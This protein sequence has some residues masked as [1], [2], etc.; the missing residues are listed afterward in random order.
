[1]HTNTPV[2]KVFVKNQFLYNMDEEIEGFTEGYIFGV[3]SMRARALLFHVMLKSGAHW[4]GLPIHSMWWYKPDADEKIEY[5]DLENLQLWDCFTEKTQVIQWDY[6]LGHQCDCFLRNK[7]VVGGEYWCSVEWLKDGNP[8]TSFVSTSDQDK[9]AHLIKLDNGQIAALPTNRIAFK[10]AYFIGNKPNPGACGYRVSESNWSAETCDR[11][12][13]SE[14]NGVFY[15]DE[16][17]KECN[18]QPE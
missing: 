17:E 15:L 3:K 18:S 2:L 1:M 13:V 4:R 8:D 12:C 7:K 16:E 5:Y 11:W 6:L 14:D 9:C 10:D